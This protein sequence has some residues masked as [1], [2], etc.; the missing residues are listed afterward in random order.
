MYQ[1]CYF[2]NYKIFEQ[3]ILQFKNFFF[4]FLIKSCSLF[5]KICT[6]AIT[7]C[8]VWRRRYVQFFIFLSIFGLANLELSVKCGWISTQRD[9]WQEHG[10]WSAM[11]PSQLTFPK[12]H[13]WVFPEPDSMISSILSCNFVCGILFS[14]LQSQFFRL[15]CFLKNS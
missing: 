12:C 15:I 8:Y 10:E 2:E 7:W 6:T 9:P 3:K 11:Y 13:H 14:S 5:Q 1:R 4:E